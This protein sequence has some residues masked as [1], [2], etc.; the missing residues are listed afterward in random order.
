MFH[1]KRLKFTD[2][3]K[4]LRRHII[5]DVPVLVFM[6]PRLYLAMFKGFAAFSTVSR[7]EKKKQRQQQ[8]PQ[9]QAAATT[10]SGNYGFRRHQVGVQRPTWKF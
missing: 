5:K 3:D 1:E 2:F 9:Q 4:I 7:R 8:Q 10:T 6:L